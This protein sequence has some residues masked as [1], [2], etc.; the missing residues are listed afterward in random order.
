MPNTNALLINK[1][2]N[3]YNSSIFKQRS[4]YTVSCQTVWRLRQASLTKIWW[5][6]LN[7]LFPSCV[8]PMFSCLLFWTCIWTKDSPG[9]FVTQPLG[10]FPLEDSCHKL[11]AYWVNLRSQRGF[12]ADFYTYFTQN[13]AI[14]I[15][16]H[17]FLVFSQ[18]STV[19]WCQ[20][21]AVEQT[22]L[23]HIFCLTTSFV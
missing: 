17:T 10:C 13:K 8:M 4:C 21:I 23:H 1:T 2:T 19:L 12:L 18:P 20:G 16:H 3:E 11:S 22:G 14:K 6:T 9:F 5:L 7:P 15:V